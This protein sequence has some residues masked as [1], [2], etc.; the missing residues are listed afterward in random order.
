MPGLTLGRSGSCRIRRRRIR[1]LLAFGRIAVEGL[2]CPK[3]PATPDCDRS[4]SNRLGLCS[5]RCPLADFRWVGPLR[6]FPGILK[7]DMPR[8]NSLTSLWFSCTGP[9]SVVM[10]HV[11][12]TAS[13][14]G[15][16]TPVTSPGICRELCRWGDY[17]PQRLA[18]IPNPKPLSDEASEG[19]WPFLVPTLILSLSWIRSQSLTR[20]FV[21]GFCRG[22]GAGYW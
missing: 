6:H 14:Q 19:I 9:E 17:S 8:L 11:G 20:V 3:C 13:S 21:L 5:T 15:D 4:P 7:S 18:P 10:S 1:P 22:R 12:D 2:R 16:L